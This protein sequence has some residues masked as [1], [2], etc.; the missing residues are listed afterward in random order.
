M[1][2]VNPVIGSGFD[3]SRGTFDGDVERI[4]GLLMDDASSN[5]FHNV[6]YN[7]MMVSIFDPILVF[8]YD[9]RL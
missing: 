7:T 6:D 9:S 8:I 4:G 1:S 3:P 5:P 2:V